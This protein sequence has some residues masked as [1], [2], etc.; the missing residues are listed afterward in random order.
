MPFT[1]AH[2]ALI[3]PLKRR[4]PRFLSL[5]ALAMGSIVPD[6]AYLLK[7]IRMDELSHS[8]IGAFVYCLPVGLVM[9]LVFRILRKNLVN[10]LPMRERRTYL[11]LCEQTDW[12]LIHLGVSL[13]LG[14]LSHLIWDSFTHNHGTMVEALPPLQIAL[15]TYHRHTLEVCHVLWYASS[16]G[17]VCYLAYEYQL[18]LHQ[19][20]V[21]RTASQSRKA[22]LI[23]LGFGLLVLP[24][25][26]AHHLVS[27][28]VGMLSV[29]VGSGVLIFFAVFCLAPGIKSVER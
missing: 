3:V 25:E 29:V 8:F 6:S 5:D 21:A 18:W 16:F 17:G 15:A 19:N 11:P 20:E 2:P 9:L 12:N 26:I 14:I 27:G 7:R 10:R 23:S 13:I 28:M 24:I 1:L 4:F 22:L